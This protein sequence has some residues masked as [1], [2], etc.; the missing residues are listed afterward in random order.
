LE[1][2]NLKLYMPHISM[3]RYGEVLETNLGDGKR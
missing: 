3:G 1:V 2:E